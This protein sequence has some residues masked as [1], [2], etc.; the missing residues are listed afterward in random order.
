MTGT[1]AVEVMSLAKALSD[2][3]G[4]RF[5]VL[6]LKDHDGKVISH[7]VYWL[8][9]DKNFKS[10]NDMQKTSVE[11]KV[12]K[13]EKGENENSWTV[14]VTNTSNRIAFFIRPQFL[15]NNTEVLP[16][17]W[18]S[19]Y[20]TLAPSESVTVKVSCPVARL[21]NKKQVIRISGWNVGAIDLHLN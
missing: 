5:V 8:A 18:S 6:N 11:A 3:K 16:S 15:Q 4:V 10:L 9:A 13:S 14:Q 12:V 20:F 7:N 2:A 1:D 21:G 17:Y 19:G